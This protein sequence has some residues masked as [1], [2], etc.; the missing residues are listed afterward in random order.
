MMTKPQFEQIKSL[1][2]SG[3][4]VS[5]IAKTL[6]MC[7]P[8][9]WKKVDRLRNGKSFIFGLEN[10]DHFQN[11]NTEEKAYWLG[12]IYADGCIYSDLTHCTTSIRLNEKDGDHL[13]KFA[14]IFNKTVTYFT[15]TYG[16]YLAEINCVRLD[17][18]NK[19][20]YQ[21]LMDNGI[22]ER[23]TYAEM[24]TILD[25]VPDLLKNHFIRGVFDGDG[26]ITS[27]SNSGQ[28]QFSIV[29]NKDIL[30]KIQKILIDSLTLNKTVLIRQNDYCW[31]LAYGGRHNIK[32]IYDYL[33]KDVVIW[34]ERKKDKFE[35]LLKLNFEWPDRV[36]PYLGAR[37]NKRNGRWRAYIGINGKYQYIKSC[38]TELEAAY[39]FD[40]EQVRQRGEDAKR[41]MNFPSKYDD[42]TRWISE[43]Y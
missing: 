10:E 31:I 3:M 4:G 26:S 22:E 23:K 18:C 32:K 15:H 29:G 42:V 27:S 33:Y 11:I 14:S 30:E 17:I 35:E 34:L 25:H 8:T 2:E 21:D 12:F 28:A 20:L 1:Y 13:Q 19:K 43:G 6:N 5:D 9:V 16:G 41:F 38:D 7:V 39:Y 37:F 24:T 40:L 36:S